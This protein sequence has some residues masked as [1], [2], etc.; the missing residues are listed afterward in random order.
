[1]S[2]AQVPYPGVDN[3]DVLSYLKGGQ[4]LEKPDE[5]PE[6]V[7]VVSILKMYIKH[8]RQTLNRQTL[9]RQAGRQTDRQADR[10][11]GRQTDRQRD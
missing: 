1:M 3:Q 8:Q 11:T 6:R 4:R 5:C 9:D 7:Y 2:L 10:Q